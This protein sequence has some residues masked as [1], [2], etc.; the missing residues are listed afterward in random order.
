MRAIRRTS[1]RRPAQRRGVVL[2]F[3]LLAVVI[4][5]TLAASFLAGNSTAIGI[6]RNTGE[7][8]QARYV[9]ESGLDFAL[10]YVRQT[11]T[12]RDD[13]TQGTW[14]AAASLAPGTFTVVAEDGA[15]LDGDGTIANPAEGDGDLA[16]D[17][18]DLL[19]LTVT[20]KV[21]GATHVARA[22]VTPVPGSP[23]KVLLVVRDPDHLSDIEQGRQDLLEGWNWDVTLIQDSASDATFSASMAEADV[24]YITAS[25]NHSYLR[26][27]C[28]AFPIGVVS[29]EAGLITYFGFA[30]S[31]DAINQAA[32]DVVDNSHYI[33]QPYATGLL[34][35]GPVAGQLKFARSTLAPGA[36]VLAEKQSSN[37]VMI[38]ALEAGSEL[39]GGGSAAARRVLLPFTGYPVSGLTADGTNLIRRA[40][41]W[42]SVTPSSP[43]P[44]LHYDF[45]A[46]SGTTVP[47][48]VGD[49]DLQF[50][51]GNG[52]LTW[53]TDSAAGTGLYFNQNS[54]SG[55][56]LARTA[57]DN[58]ANGLKS[59]LQTSQA[60]TVQVFL[61]AEGFDNSYGRI[62]S[63]SRDTGSTTRN[64][65]LAADNDGASTADLIGRVKR[66][67]SESEYK[68]D[69]VF[70]MNEYQVLAF[71]VDLNQS[72]S[73]II[74]Y[75]D[76]EMVRTYSG[77]G[78]FDSWTSEQF[79]LGNEK[80]RDRPFQ[81][82]LYDVKI[83]DSA[84]S[85]AQLRAEAE[86]L[87]PED[88]ESPQLIALYEFNEVPP[89]DPVLVGHW[90]LDEATGSGG[91]TP[92]MALTQSA[93]FGGSHA[94][95][96]TYNST[97]GA[98]GPGNSSSSA[99]VSVNAT[100]SNKITLWS[101]A[102]LK[103][104]AYIGPG[105]DP[106]RGIQTWSGSKITG[107][108]GTLSEE[109]AM[110]TL[111][112]PTGS[113]FDDPPMGNCDNWG[114]MVTKIDSDRHYKRMGI[115]GSSKVQIEGHV[116]ILLDKQLEI[117][118]T[119]E[120]EILPDSSL[121]LYTYKQLDI[122]SKL[123]VSTQ[124]PSKLR[125]YMLGG[126]KYV[127]LWG[128]AEIHALIQ[129]PTGDL[130]LWN[131]TQFYGT[132][133]GR[134]FEGNG[135]VHIDLDNCSGG[136]GGGGDN[137]AV[138]EV[139]GNDGTYT[140]GPIGAQTGCGDGGTAVDFDGSNDYVLI[141]HSDS[142]LLD[143]GAVSF[144][145]NSDG[146]SGHHALFSKDSSDYDTGGHLHIYTDGS[147]VKARLQ[148]TGASYELS[149][150]SGVSSE[151]WHHVV[152]NFGTG[153]MKLYVDDNLVDSDNY[154][155]GLGTS[156]G[157]S[158]NHE[159][160][161][162]GAG[163][164]S[165][166]NLTHESLNY[167][168]AGQ[169]DGVRIYDYP[170]DA[171]Q[172]SD[173]FGGGEVGPGSGVGSVVQ[174][175]SEYGAAL[176][177]TIENTDNVTWI[178]GGGLSFDAATKATST[179]AAGKLYS[180]LTDTDEMTLEVI[181]TPANLSQSGPARIVSYSNDTSNRNF[182]FGQTQLKYIQRVRTSTTSSNGT[183][184]IEALP[185]LTTSSQHHVVV[186]FDGEYVKMYRNGALEVTSEREGNL[187]NWNATYKLLLA[188]EDTDNRPWL[189]S[190]YRVAVYDRALS[191]SQA[192]DLF[193]G[194]P[195][196]DPADSEYTYDAAWRDG[197]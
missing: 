111:S 192:D 153:G 21:N 110:P 191:A 28:R 160:L 81:G 140:G 29:E 131:E 139:S 75:V 148:S 121:T 89:P 115:W 11:D 126:G 98:Y 162:L 72:T 190:L 112:P 114:S 181:F 107:I 120:L 167:Y 53:V 100:G 7:H 73:N 177:L 150:G 35:I 173:L 77:S 15:D 132:Y 50:D 134:R 84:L 54:Q 159:P 47:D 33:T 1:R 86:Q 188:N 48:V 172:V 164:W 166:G 193:A 185:V 123:N 31:Y 51:V 130:R 128:R 61:K 106:D 96:D 124:D 16:D 155:G 32:I 117:T 194:M 45:S 105:G 20:G 182:T 129:N 161:V 69:N 145:F 57:N 19:T 42:A 36:E 71:T 197:P 195:P 26:S 13:R 24:M 144:W 85:A 6:A 46:Q 94:V 184:D 183:P 99:C 68:Q 52:A 104:D 109:V 63:Y 14:V 67:S 147:R 176:D 163:T 3:T 186:T 49:V 108:R 133:L 92:G 79:M 171:G 12:W 178:D 151:Q 25:V 4:A 65:T 40:L 37:D 149:S 137:T 78:S 196:Q 102:I 62:L 93:D 154:A 5:T 127:A 91:G 8:A 113:P 18:S 74:L 23:L 179:L 119:A 82:Y 156:S 88:S 187:G 122:G 76:G 103:G 87:L 101:N 142:Y 143:R 175:T 10:A 174:D 66:Y 9:A 90:R 170:L 27:R 152:V 158:G 56:A 95:I 30:R 83:W 38:M 189:G 80:T 125:I 157:G 64:F 180:A 168:F 60:F 41:T 97:K 141:P 39:Y 138:D 70:E 59:A 118:E 136:G 17:L 43:G 55:T 116:T 2:V 135:G 58:V 169:L 44:I 22:V 165:S 34:T 146:M